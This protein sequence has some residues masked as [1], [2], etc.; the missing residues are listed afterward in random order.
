MMPSCCLVRFI[1]NISALTEYIKS[2][3][4]FHRLPAIYK[5]IIAVAFTGIISLLLSPVRMEAMARIM[6]G[7]DIFSLFMLAMSLVTFFSLC[8]A[9]IRVL[10]G[11][12]DSSRVVV[13]FIIVVGAMCSLAGV[14][15]LLGSKG[16]WLLSKGMETFI[17]ISGVTF[18]WILLHTIF[19]FRYAHLYYG[20]HATRKNEYAGG[21]DIPEE[22]HPDY[23]DFAY[24]SF[25]IGMTFQVSD[26][27]I[28]SRKIR[29]L[30]LM[31]G[32]LSF[33][34]NTVIVALTINAV[35]ELRS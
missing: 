5:L 17:Y 18:S 28:S 34:F 10:A 20:D 9:E 14:M 35:V 19:T 25:V 31:H 4:W 29:R 33:I 2:P 16:S 27:Q 30:A 21:L 32:L 8:P 13:F 15:I 24:F 22:K 26:I 3:G 12:E 6:T 23:L 11:N 7:W 1:F